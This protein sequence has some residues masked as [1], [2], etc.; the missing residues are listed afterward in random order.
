MQILENKAPY[1]MSKLITYDTH[2]IANSLS[3]E[4]VQFLEYSGFSEQNVSGGDERVRMQRL[5]SKKSSTLEDVDN[6][7]NKCKFYIQQDESFIG[8][9]ETEIITIDEPI[10]CSPLDE[11]VW[12][13]MPLNL[14]PSPCP[15]GIYKACDV[16]L[17]LHK[18]SPVVNKK[19]LE[20]GFYYLDLSKSQLG[21]VRVYTMQTQS[22]KVGRQIFETL[23]KTL[24]K[25]GGV[26]GSL[27]FEVTRSLYNH[28]FLLPPIILS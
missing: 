6:L 10:S 15:E 21:N 22:Q 26:E 13:A 9:I 18:A 2:L 4:V 27:K 25:G 28:G 7:F 3:Q 24:E 14:N 8:Y 1:P 23:K 5:W 16:H 19:L 17:S 20:S 11:M 12:D